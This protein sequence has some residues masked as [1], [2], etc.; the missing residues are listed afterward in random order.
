MKSI[1]W[2]GGWEECRAAADNGEFDETLT[3]AEQ[4][5]LCGAAGCM[6]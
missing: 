5:A 1:E 4:D 2:K 3:E 6:L